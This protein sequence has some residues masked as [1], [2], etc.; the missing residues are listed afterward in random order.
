MI[1]SYLKMIFSWAGLELRRRHAP[2]EP[3]RHRTSERCK[4]LVEMHRISLL[5]DAGAN[6][7]QY[8]R[9]FR[10]FGY[11]G[12]IASFEPLAKAFT[13]LN[14]YASADPAGSWS[15]FHTALGDT[16]LVNAAFNVASYSE[17]SS[18]LQI[19][20]R[21]VQALPESGFEGTEQVRV[22][23]LDS[24]RSEFLQ[25]DDRVWLKL[26][27]QGFE[28]NVLLGATDTLREVQVIDIELSLVPVYEGQA[29]IGEML[30]FLDKIGFEPVSFE[31]GFVEPSTGHALQVDGLFVRRPHP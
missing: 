3:F 24:L 21:H 10:S 4:R 19:S 9:A 2:Q 1:K 20:K 16:D 22:R 7:G 12:R 28:K 29:M 13:T 6:E 17:C 27:V 26:D 14:R 31:N 18:F 8:A 5:L 30:N 25:T 23:K 11:T 15:C